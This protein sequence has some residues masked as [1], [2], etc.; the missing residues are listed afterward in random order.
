[1]PFG[2]PI[3]GMENP[4]IT[5]MSPSVIR[6]GKESENVAAHEIVH[7]WFGN[8]ITCKNWTHTWINEGFTVYGERLILEAFFGE[9]YYQTAAA[10]GLHDLSEQVELL[11]NS[12]E[13]TKLVIHTNRK[14]PDY[15]FTQIAYEKGFVFLKKLEVLY[16]LTNKNT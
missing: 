3:G 10:I 15:G 11:K 5:F 2:Y 14:F 4:E 12:P 6:S 1:M 16:A 8:L 13:R 9:E 7:S